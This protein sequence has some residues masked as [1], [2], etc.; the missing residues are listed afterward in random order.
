VPWV[1]TGVN[2]MTSYA[3][4]DGRTYPAGTMLVREYVIMSKQQQILN[5][6]PSGCWARQ[7][8]NGAWLHPLEP[9]L[10]MNNESGLVTIVD[11]HRWNETS[12]AQFLG[13]IPSETPYFEEYLRML[14]DDYVPFCQ[15]RGPSVWLSIWNE[16]FMWDGSDGV[17][18]TKWASEMGRILAVVRSAGYTGVVVVPAGRMGQDESVLLAEGAALAASYAPIVYDVHAYERWTRDSVESV[19][20]RLAALRSAGVAVI[21]GEVGPANAGHVVD[22]WPFLQEA[23]DADVGVL[24]WIWKCTSNTADYNAMKTCDSDGYALN[25]AGNF[26]W[27]S[28]FTDYIA[29]ASARQARRGERWL[30]ER[31]HREAQLVVKA[32][33]MVQVTA[34]GVIRVG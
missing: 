28:G 21:I 25:D 17:N 14:A 16:P 19:R 31:G 3:A 23:A 34:G 33:G 4:A 26:G 32:G 24:G 9:L 7:L 18:A 11:L 12:Q 29:A 22:P 8:S 2:A 5:C 27:G 1:P 6:Y 15:A 13:T 30:A 10:N 20:S